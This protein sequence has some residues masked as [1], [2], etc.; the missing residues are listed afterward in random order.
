MNPS[1]R[2]VRSGNAGVRAAGRS[3]FFISSI[4]TYNCELRVEGI[5][6]QTH[7]RTRHIITWT[8]S[9]VL[10]RGFL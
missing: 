1:G 7:D 4:A 9:C 3:F 5:L 10:V 2:I 6:L 8:R